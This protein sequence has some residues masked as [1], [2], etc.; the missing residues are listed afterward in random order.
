MAIF[1]AIA[2]AVVSAIGIT[3]TAATIFTAIGAT[4]L[5]VGA[6]RLLMKRQMAKGQSGGSGGARIQ[7]PPATENKLPVVYGSAYIGGSVTDAKI[8]SDNKTMWY[9]V[10][11]AEVTDTGGYTFD[12]SNIYYNGLKVQFGS[13]GVVTGLINNTTPATVDT[14]M[15]GQ[16]YI[17]LFQNGATSAGQN[18][19]QTA[20]Q[21]MQDAGIPAGQRWTATDLMSDCAFAIVKVKYNAEKGTTSLG[22]IT[23][24]ITNSL[25]Q[26]GSVIN[27]YMQN[28]R[29]G[30][31]IPASAIDTASLTALNTYS[32]YP[33]PYTPAGGGSATQDRYSINGPIATGNDCLTNLQI[34]VDSCD[35]WLQYNEV[36]AQWR[37]II[38]QSYTDYTTLT[39]LFLVDSNNL[40]GG[41]NVA[42]INLNETFNQLEVAYPNESVRD[43]TDY[44]LIN[45]VDYAPAVMSPNEAVN[46]LDV[47]FPVVHTSV[48]SVYLGI[49]RL[50]QSREDL[51]ITFATDYSGIQIEAGDVIR[52][53]QEVYGWDLLNSGEGKLFRVANVAE[54]KYQDGSLGA[55][56]TAFEYN[57]TVYD[58]FA[59]TEYAP[60]PNTGLQ[61]PNIMDTPV[62][63]RTFLDNTTSINTLQIKAT[64]PDVGLFT[65]LEINYGATTNTESHI[66]YTSTNNGTGEPLTSKVDPANLIIGEEYSIN[67]LGTTNFAL[68]G[69]NKVDLGQAY[70]NTG[71]APGGFLQNHK[72][73][74]IETAGT[75]D[76]TVCGATSNTVGEIFTANNIGTGTG[77]ALE[78]DFVASGTTSGDGVADTIVTFYMNDLLDGEYYWSTTAKNETQGVTGPA[79]NLVI[80]DGPSTSTFQQFEINNAYSTGNTI[81]F[82]PAF[83]FLIPGGTLRLVATDS[84]DLLADTY[85]QQINSNVQFEMNQAPGNA[86]SNGVMTIS[87]T[88]SNVDIGTGTDSG[89]VIGGVTGNSI[90]NN[91]VGF[92][93]A[94]GNIFGREL[95]YYS[96]T[97]SSLTPSPSGTDTQPVNWNTTI[98]TQG[99]LFTTNFAQPKYITRNSTVISSTAYHNPWWNG[100]ASILNGF[101]D[102]STA[103]TQPPYS[104]QW[105]RGSN[106]TLGGGASP[107]WPIEFAEMKLDGRRFIADPKNVIKTRY[108][109]VMIP[110]QDCFV[111]VDI[112]GHFVTDPDYAMTVR[113]NTNV[114]YPLYAN[115]PNDVSIEVGGTGINNA[116]D[117]FGVVLRILTPG[118][119][120]TISTG[121]FVLND[122]KDDRTST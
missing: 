69:A 120:V 40:V 16:I 19:S 7:L 17:Y 70:G 26:P 37:V 90:A 121:T 43:Q 57:D 68:V 95:A 111:Q 27:D 86:I 80:W 47:D 45:L 8:S 24:R 50:L 85:I 5:S 10:A 52:V 62:A 72:Q 33:L 58:D 30:C 73:Y 56:I 77:T 34:L 38:N 119:T 48:Q 113:D 28:T 1:T 31:A 98:G 32:T 78:T 14:K 99:S 75:T 93:Q 25:S 117:G 118:T 65:N 46:K 2:A 96:Y 109:S 71:P 15:S 105:E 108:S 36:S 55:R 92:D 91:S 12:T 67:S 79:G 74:I 44:Q 100:V 23:A 13:N 64:V 35:S 103:P 53:K 29:Y 51:T 11:M 54:E 116:V 83:D 122:T 49:R 112:F 94:A 102:T 66:F 88:Y 82:S 39:D 18:T 97:I 63:P 21:I 101:L 107:V 6:S 114:I 59:L 22:G 3:G 4:V 61:N 89:N 60:S 81:D 20:Q 84:G 41:I 76:W 9:C 106:Q 110:D 115:V 42:P 87:G 104:S